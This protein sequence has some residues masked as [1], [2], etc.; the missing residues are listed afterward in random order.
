MGSFKL[1]IMISTLL[2]SILL[3]S[4]SIQCQPTWS[5]KI[6]FYPAKLYIG[7]WGQVYVNIT[8]MDC[9]DR[10][11]YLMELKSTHERVINEIVERSEEM[12]SISWIEDY[13]VEVERMWGYGGEVYGDYKLTILGACNGRAVELA[14]AGV[15]FPFKGI[16][17]AM[18]FWNNTRK[19]LEAFNPLIYIMNGSHGGSSIVLIFKVFI[20]EDIPSEEISMKPSI[21]IRLSFPGWMEYTLENYPTAENNVEIQP[22]RTFNLTVTDFDGLNVLPGAKLILRRL[23]YYYDVREYI[24][25]ENGTVRI[26]RLL[27][28]KY[29][30]EVYWSSLHYLQQYPHVY[31]EQHWAYELASSKIIKTRL[32]NLRIKP[33]DIHGRTLNGASIIL[34]GVAETSEDGGAVY[35]MVPQGNHTV[36]VFWRNIKVFD[37]WVWAGYHPT[38][39]P[40][41]TMPAVEH[42]V[43]TSVGDLVVQ[44]VDSGGN[45]MGANFTVIGLNPETSIGDIYSRS[46]LLNISQLPI[47]DYL[48]RAVNTSRIFNSTVSSEKVFK[49]GEIYYLELPLY[50]VKLKIIDAGGEHLDGA[51]VSLESIVKM[52]GKDGEA[53]FT[54]VPIGGRSLKVVFLGVE[55]YE[56]VIDVSGEV[57]VELRVEVFDLELEVLN[58]AGKPVRI[59]YEL[60]DPA[61]RRFSNRDVESIIIEDLLDGISTL[62][63]YYEDRV[64]YTKEASVKELS[65][66][67]WINLPISNLKVVVEYADGEPLEKAQ[68]DVI[69]LRSGEKY[70]RLTDNN[71]VIL[72][73]NRPF[74][75]YRVIVY[76]PYT[77]LAVAGGEV[78]FSGQEIRYALEKTMVTVRVVDALGRPVE[79]A[80]VSISY[81][82][83]PISKQKTNSE[84]VAVFRDIVKLPLYD[85]HVSFG[86][87]SGSGRVEPEKSIEVKMPSISIFGITLYLGEVSGIL[88]ILAPVAVIIIIIFIMSRLLGRL[89]KEGERYAYA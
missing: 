41:M 49:P 44:A 69:D 43:A 57:D 13:R 89:F 21:D 80:E 38:I 46:G 27:D 50:P 84:G 63:I 52:S 85:V 58:H 45:P 17:R 31:F 73:E 3:L 23:I 32:F 66:M 39:Y 10:S 6:V 47:G 34:D 86:G 16:A 62:K 40:W 60:V 25:Q 11:N 71:G 72:F 75:E 30:V 54:G 68:V 29:Q 24:V 64:V 87:L 61:G 19:S 14:S 5:L 79:D 74:S 81:L 37:G 28:D 35:P 7:E 9:S 22:Y 59:S 36:Q 20:P 70:S 51:E 18:T 55:V 8:N 4:S 12:K 56:G 82:D 2:L 65:I 26:T 67:R 53:I 48:V 88:Y 42:K 78:S 15:W 83:N 76:Y 33:V 1:I 77:R